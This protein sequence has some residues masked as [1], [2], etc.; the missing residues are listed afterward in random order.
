MVALMRKDE[1]ALNNL[2]QEADRGGR[3][4]TTVVN[5]CELYAGAY[6]SRNPP[7]E[8]DKIERL[9]SQLEVLELKTEASKKYGELL[10]HPAMRTQRIG[11]FDLIIAAIAL[12]YGE[13][14]CTRNLEHFRRVPELIVEQW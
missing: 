8:L 1:K 9:V 4:S 7:K 5:L 12:C 2:R 13:S 14:M 11:D 3:V 10:S 6:A